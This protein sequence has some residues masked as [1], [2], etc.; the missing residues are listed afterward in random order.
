VPAPNAP[1]RPAS[2]AAS[3]IPV[4]VRRPDPPS[5][6]VTS[7]VNVANDGAVKHPAATTST[8]GKPDGTVNN[9]SISGPWGEHRRRANP[10]MLPHPYDTSR[11]P[12]TIMK[13]RAK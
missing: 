13:S 10:P 1:A 5:I 11:H 2:P 3:H 9:G 6:P 12:P 4:T 8:A 7:A